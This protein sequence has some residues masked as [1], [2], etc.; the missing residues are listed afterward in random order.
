MDYS[1]NINFSKL[2]KSC[3]P[4]TYAGSIAENDKPVKIFLYY[5]IDP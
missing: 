4:G 1:C 3:Y 5:F 2:T